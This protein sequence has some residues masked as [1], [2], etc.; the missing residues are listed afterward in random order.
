[1]TEPKHYRLVGPDGML[2]PSSTP[3]TLGG[4]RA[5]KVYGRLDCRAALRAIVR[6]GYIKHRVF[7]KDESTAIAARYRPCAVCLP[8]EYAI[9]KDAIRDSETPKHRI[10]AN[11]QPRGP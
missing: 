8:A 7:F 2:Y 10:K 9:W 1:M 4:N 6:G 3:G 11:Q 5:S